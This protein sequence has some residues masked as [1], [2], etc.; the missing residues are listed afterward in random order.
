[1][2][3]FLLLLLS[4]TCGSATQFDTFSIISHSGKQAAFLGRKQR[5]T[6]SRPH[7]K[8]LTRSVYITSMICQ[9][10]NNILSHTLPTFRLVDP[11][12]PTHTHTHTS[13]LHS[14]LLAVST[15][16]W[17]WEKSTYSLQHV[18]SNSKLLIAINQSDQ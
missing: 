4:N 15:K 14:H 18:L 16:I 1:M 8:P 13:K 6:L 12:P 7:N 2:V 11:P 10:R 5:S 9:T 17:Y 3:S